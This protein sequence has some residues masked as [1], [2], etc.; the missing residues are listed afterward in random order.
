MNKSYIKCSECG[1]VN[2]NNE[3]CSN[4]NALLDVVLKRRLKSESKIQEKIDQERDKKPNKIE[5][6]LK[7]GLEHSNIIIRLFFK[8]AYAIWL[9]FA[10]IIGGIIAAVTAAAAG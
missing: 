10:F 1:T 3:Y 5:V 8:A 7:N 4:C 6:F 2:Y 9:F